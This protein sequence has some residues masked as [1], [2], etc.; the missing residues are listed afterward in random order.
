MCYAQEC[1]SNKCYE[2]LFCF[3]F[4]EMCFGLFFSLQLEGFIVCGGRWGVGGVCV[5]VSWHVLVN[6]LIG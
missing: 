6:K 1:V 2:V 5:C 3:Y 4:Y